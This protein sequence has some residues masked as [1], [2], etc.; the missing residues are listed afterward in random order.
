MQ[1]SMCS[2]AAAFG[3]NAAVQWVVLLGL[4]CRGKLAVHLGRC[5]HAMGGGGK[6]ELVGEM[7]IVV[8]GEARKREDLGL[9]GSAPDGIDRGSQVVADCE[10]QQLT[11]WYCWG[12]CVGGK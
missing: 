6:G 9:C 11:E 4:D 12:K 5:G 10:K 3:E 7:G 8:E 1:Q 2:L